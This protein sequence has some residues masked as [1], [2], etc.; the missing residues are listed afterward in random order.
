[1]QSEILGP[2]LLSF[3]SP[4]AVRTSKRC[5]FTMYNS[6]KIAIRSKLGWSKMIKTNNEGLVP[7]NGFIAIP[8]VYLTGRTTDIHRYMYKVRRW[9]LLFLE[10]RNLRGDALH[11]TRRYGFFLQSGWR[12]KRVV[13]IGWSRNEQLK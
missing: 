6:I 13:R 10:E 1:M 11:E 12:R 4:G 9:R 8:Q 5:W 2:K 7:K 3:K